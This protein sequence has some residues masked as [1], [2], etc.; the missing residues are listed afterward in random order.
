MA[1]GDGLAEVLAALEQDSPAAAVDVRAE[2]AALAA[3]V[4]RSSPG[5]ATRGPRRSGCRW[6]SSPAPSTSARATRTGRPPSCAG[7][8]V[9]PPPPRY[10]R[11][12]AELAMAAA[13]LGELTV[14]ALATAS[15]TG[16][17][18][19]GSP[20]ASG[21]VGGTGPCRPA[22]RAGPGS[23][24][25]TGRSRRRLRPSRSG[26]AAGEDP[27]GAARRPRRARRA[28][29]GED[30][31]CA[32]RPRCCGSSRCGARRV[33]A[34][35][36]SRATSCS[37]ATRGPARRRS[38]ASSRPST[39]PSSNWLCLCPSTRSLVREIGNGRR[40]SAA[41]SRTTRPTRP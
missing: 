4:C 41:E 6:V 1:D 12:L 37:S 40:S 30:A 35:P 39:R 5:A 9:R 7:W 15:V 19:L 22:R 36:T 33:C 24:P 25:P 27:R 34:T 8:P 26:H 3:A 29:R 38:P 16:N 20:R 17:A 14:S 18:Q 2:A 13:S 31:R 21:G 10:A 32:A 23:R 28:P 11:H